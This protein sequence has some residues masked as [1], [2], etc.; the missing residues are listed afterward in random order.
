MLAIQKYLWQSL[1]YIIILD[2]TATSS[3][4]G[5]NVPSLSG[6]LLTESCVSVLETAQLLLRYTVVLTTWFGRPLCAA[7]KT[8]VE[9]SL[10]SCRSLELDSDIRYK[11]VHSS[12]YSPFVLDSKSTSSKFP[13][14]TTSNMS[15]QLIIKLTT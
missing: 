5:S 6:V 14:K 8:T 4:L 15:C 12:V 1:L 2:V 10:A 7:P 13:G 11:R 9:L 3:S